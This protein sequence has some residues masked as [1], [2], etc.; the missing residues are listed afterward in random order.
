MIKG[1]H[2]IRIF[3]LWLTLA[4]AGVGPSALWAQSVESMLPAKFQLVKSE[5]ELTEDGFYLIGAEYKVVDAGMK[6][7]FCLLTN[8]EG[9]YSLL[10]VE[11][12]Y[13]VAEALRVEN[14]NRIWQLKKAD[15]GS[16]YLC[17]PSSGEGIAQAKSKSGLVMKE[18]QWLSWSFSEMGEGKFRLWLSSDRERALGL[19]WS[20][21]AILF[22]TYK[23]GPMA[24]SDLRI[25]KM[26]ESGV[27]LPGDAVQPADGARVAL[28]AGEEV[29]SC[30]DS[31]WTFK[32]FAPLLLQNQTLADDSS[33]VIWRCDENE[34]HSFVLKDNEGRGLEKII[35]SVPENT[36]WT[37]HN[38]FL[39]SEDLPRRYLVFDEEKHLKFEPFE[40]FKNIKVEA[41]R[42][43][44]VGLPA[45]SSIN[46]EGVK[47]LT[48]SWSA[49]QLADVDW[50]G[51][52][53]L[54]L[55]AL[56]LPAAAHPFSSYPVCCNAMIYISEEGE[57]FCPPEWKNVALRDEEGNYRLRDVCTL[58]DRRS[59]SIDR[60]VSIK[61]A[62]VVYQRDALA[63][64]YWETLCLPFDASVPADFLAERWVG[65]ADDGYTLLFEKTEVIVANEPLIFRYVGQTN[66]AVADFT[67]L[68]K[69]KRIP[70]RIQ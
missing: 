6:E 63:D 42:L 9:K 8:V 61:D 46:A 51:V 12:V 31:D 62:Q 20:R 55:T 4:F 15:A 11:S 66:Q 40:A 39:V 69:K 41:V 48:G 60:K 7:G 36:N 25:Y 16:F 49:A 32:E 30:H 14:P 38:G 13:P 34:N 2:E 52:S 57:N 58:I 64:G 17:D 22:G 70:F 53:A 21:M 59:W 35:A 68:L 24:V 43:V 44:P 5:K 26:V 3:V 1:I 47:V 10:G 67:V 56:S 50:E 19:N 37:I 29:L 45:D 65:F 27:A 23:P 54:D 18:R 28:V 33:L